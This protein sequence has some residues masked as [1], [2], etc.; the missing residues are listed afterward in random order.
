MNTL[1]A[2]RTRR[3]VR[4]F[5]GEPVERDTIR[6]LVAAGTSAPSA[7]NQQ[8]WHFVAIDD[9]AL[10]RR[11]P[12]FHQYARMAESAA[13]GI[14]VCADMRL[15]QRQGYWVQ[16]CAAATQ[17]I[18]LAAHDL[19]LGAVWTGI[20]P[21]DERVAGVRELF[22]LPEEVRPLSLVFLGHP[23]EHPAPE[24]RYREER[25]HWNRW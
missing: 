11:V 14:L 23:A 19:G 7:G 17:N 24:D 5:T 3:S 1:E 8:L 22:A 18:L 6:K 25:V 13:A 21:R 20:Y 10:L 9:C 16:D 15:E 12:E 4:A 2:I